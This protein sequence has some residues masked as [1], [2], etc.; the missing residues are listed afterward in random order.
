MQH[1]AHK[2]HTFHEKVYQ[3]LGH[4]LF[5]IKIQQQ[6]SPIAKEG[7]TNQQ[8]PSKNSGFPHGIQYKSTH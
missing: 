1:L 5:K 2:G 3:I 4:R 8:T 7:Q 6:K